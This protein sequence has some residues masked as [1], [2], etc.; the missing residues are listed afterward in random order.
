MV[1]EILTSLFSII[2]KI[3]AFKLEISTSQI[4]ISAFQL[5]ISNLVDFGYLH[6][7]YRYIL[8]L[9]ISVFEISEFLN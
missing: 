2:R 8:L 6:S 1:F 3:I 5:D 7:N 9:N 4:Q